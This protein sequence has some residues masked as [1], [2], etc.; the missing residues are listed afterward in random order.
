MSQDLRPKVSTD[1]RP[2]PPARLNAEC[3]VGNNP[4]GIELPNAA[5]RRLEVGQRVR[6]RDPIESETPEH[7]RPAGA[8]GRVVRID[9]LDDI[10]YA[11]E[12]EGGAIV[13]VPSTEHELARLEL[14][15]NPAGDY[16]HD[17]TTIQGA[18]ELAKNQE[19]VAEFVEAFGDKR[20]AGKS[21]WEA[22]RQIVAEWEL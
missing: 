9:K 16:M 7:R 12:I 4:F 20:A 21:V 6:F 15:G 22:V 18:L 10:E 8:I 5:P 3:I 11:I 2:L 13:H 19:C 14:L 1:E 17:L